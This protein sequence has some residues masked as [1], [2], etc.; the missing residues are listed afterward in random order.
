MDIQKP[1]GV[2]EAV[3]REPQ[4]LNALRRGSD[5][6]AA[7]AFESF[8]AT[9]LVREMRKS[10]PSGFFAGPGADVYTSWLDEHLGETLAAHDALGLAGLLK[11][12]VARAR[13]V[14]E[15]DAPPGGGDHGAE[16]DAPPGGGA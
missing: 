11:A 1:I 16:P 5:E 8:F 3:V 4:V 15:A 9:M 10:L 2:Q 13:E 6:E 14:A 12:A 7:R